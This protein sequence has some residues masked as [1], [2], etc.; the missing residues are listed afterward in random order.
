MARRIPEADKLTTSMLFKIGHQRLRRLEQEVNA[1][2][3]VAV[4]I[5]ALLHGRAEEAHLYVHLTDVAPTHR[6]RML[7]QEIAPEG[8]FV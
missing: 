4:G 6:Q 8:G 7:K 5:T 1:R 3:E 2:Q